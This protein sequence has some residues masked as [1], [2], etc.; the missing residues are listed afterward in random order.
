MNSKAIER[1]LAL[2]LVGSI[3]A[4]TTNNTANNAPSPSASNSPTTSSSPT[5][6]AKEGGEGGEGEKSKDLKWAG[7][8]QDK[9]VIQHFV[10]AIVLPKYQ[11]FATATGQLNQ[12]LGALATTPTPATLAAA[13]LAWQQARTDWEVT[14]SFA[15][16]PAGSL[17]YDGALDSW[18]V[19]EADVQKILADRHQLDA[20][21]IAD[22]D[23]G[24]KGMHTIELLLYGAKNNKPLAQFTPRERQYLAALGQDLNTVAGKLLQSWQSGIDGQPAYQ[25]VLTTA[26]EASNT[27][28]PQVAAAAQEMVSGVIGSVTEVGT[29]K[30]GT[31][32]AKQDIKTLES[33]FAENTRS[34]LLANL[35]GAQ[36]VYLGSLSGQAVANSLSAYVAQKNSQ[37]DRQIQAEFRAALA[38]LQAIP[39]PLEKAITATGD[40]PKLKASLAALSKLQTTLETQLAPLI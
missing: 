15:F 40:L 23:D 36:A 30:L 39:N 35:S 20:A 27:S 21:A 8:F 12:A 28:Y 1:F 17:G 13:K 9:A 6:S 2:A 34:D 19:N 16:G 31:A 26:G 14:E 37:L 25:K 5:S 7:T 18:P 32:I 22:L 38:S 33:R 11:K 4:C 3:A 10:T 29:E 24:Q